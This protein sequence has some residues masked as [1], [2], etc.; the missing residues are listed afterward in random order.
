LPMSSDFV[1]WSLATLLGEVSPPL[2]RAIAAEALTQIPKEIIQI[3]M[4][5]ISFPRIT[6]DHDQSAI[7][8]THLGAA[9]R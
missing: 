5:F 8:Q 3:T 9:A 4:R 2:S 6:R 7:V 1:T